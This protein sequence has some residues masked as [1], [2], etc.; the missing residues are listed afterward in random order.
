MIDR[1]CLAYIHVETGEEKL[2]DTSDTID[3]TFQSLL[4]VYFVTDLPHSLVQKLQNAAVIP[5]EQSIT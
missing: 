4:N 2:V 3:T 1:N 5:R